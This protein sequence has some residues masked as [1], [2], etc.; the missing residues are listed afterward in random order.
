MTMLPFPKLDFE[1]RK[2]LPILPDLHIFFKVLL[3]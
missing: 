3:R 1:R 2:R